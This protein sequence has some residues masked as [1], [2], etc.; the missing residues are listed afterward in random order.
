MLDETG[1]SVVHTNTLTVLTRTRNI[2]AAEDEFS[3]P[4]LVFSRIRMD[5]KLMVD[6]PDGSIYEIQESGW[7]SFV[8]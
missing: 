8:Y 2:N 1:V 5:V 6:A 3:P 7:I 4:L